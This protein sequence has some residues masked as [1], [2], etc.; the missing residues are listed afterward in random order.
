MIETYATI[1]VWEYII[2]GAIIWSFL[3]V[4]F[5]AWICD[6]LESR[7][8]KKR[9]KWYNYIGGYNM[10]YE[11]IVIDPD[12]TKLKYKEKE[13]TI[14]KDIALMN[15]LQSINYIAKNNMIIDLAKKGLT[16]DD[17]IIKKVENGKKYEDERSIREM[18]R[19]YLIMASLETFNKICKK[20]T[21]MDMETLM[22][23]IG[24]SEQK[25]SEEGISE[26]LPVRNGGMRNLRP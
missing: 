20:Y 3:L 17:L 19:N 21:K 10:K 8:A 14:V 24:L 6:K 5:M 2:A 12:T 16:P 22:Q 26:A 11:F 9:K 25:E 7:F 13:F 15:E 18:E 23:D 1:R 4:M